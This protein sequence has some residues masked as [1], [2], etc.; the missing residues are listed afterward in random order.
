MV[1][2]FALIAKDTQLSVY[3]YRKGPKEDI[4]MVPYCSHHVGE[5]CLWNLDLE[6][7]KFCSWNA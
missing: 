6:S 5:Y 2:A 1:V 4:I 7:G 3:D